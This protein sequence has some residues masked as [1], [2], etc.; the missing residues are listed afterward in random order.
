MSR[1]GYKLVEVKPGVM[2]AFRSSDEV[3]E[4]SP[5]IFEGVPKEVA[6]KVRHSIAMNAR[7]WGHDEEEPLPTPTWN[8]GGKDAPVLS[9]DGP[10][11]L[12]VWDFSDRNR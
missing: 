2:Q 11:S 3:V 6:A 5:G 7:S 12:P 10:L 4:I 1:P 8:F 9:D